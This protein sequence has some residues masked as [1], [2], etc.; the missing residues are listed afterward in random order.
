MRFKHL[1][2]GGKNIN[3]KE[4]INPYVSKYSMRNNIKTD[5]EIFTLKYFILMYHV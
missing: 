5:K 2:F 3:L 4:N 1:F